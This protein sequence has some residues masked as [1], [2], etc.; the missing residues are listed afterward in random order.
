M[1][2]TGF[3]LKI[4]FNNADYRE[5]G[6]IL[7]AERDWPAVLAE[8]LREGVAPLFYYR[9]MKRGWEVNLPAEV[10]DQ[11]KTLFRQTIRL[12]SEAITCLGMIKRSFDAGGIPWIVLK[13]IALAETVYPHF[14]LRPAS[15]IDVLVPRRDFLKAHAALSS[16]GYRAVDSLPGEALGNPEGYLASVEYRND[17]D[18]PPIHLH[19]HPVNT[20]TPAP[21]AR[22]IDIEALWNNSRA[23]LI[24]GVR[25]RIFLPEHLLMY[26]CEHALRVG[27]SFDRLNLICDIQHTVLA[28]Q[29]EID[30]TRFTHECRSSG[31]SRFAYLALEIVR[32]H[33]GL[34]ALDEPI[35]ML[36][37]GRLRAG[38]RLFLRLQLAGKRIRGSS[39]LLY[40][41]A[42]EGIRA[43]A[44]FLLKTFFPPRSVLKQKNYQGRLPFRYA[45]YLRRL[46]EVTGHLAYVL[47]R[48]L[49]RPKR[50]EGM[51]GEKKP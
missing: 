41:G 48:A 22:A 8:C 2:E 33:S 34:R 5:I 37:P 14:A 45:L 17:S 20:S 31:L 18:S 27:H 13:G 21:F 32:K 38:E 6:E 4:L 7:S 43:K 35:A 11:F 25:S 16:M 28:Y 3:I 47:R 46:I 1:K 9:I 19:W 50:T 44:Q 51:S 39:F 23:V 26:L 15:D 29:K 10:L 40:L 42:N 49:S 36:K 30:W 12:N 24:G